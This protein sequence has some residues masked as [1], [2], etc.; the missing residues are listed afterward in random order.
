V[1][2][3]FF[4]FPADRLEKT[5]NGIWLSL[6]RLLQLTERSLPSAVAMP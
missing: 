1:I 3:G 6:L 2:V 4:I 5:S